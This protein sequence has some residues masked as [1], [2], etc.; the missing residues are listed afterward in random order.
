MSTENE[1]RLQA[2]NKCWICNKLFDAQDDKVREHC[3]TAGKYRGSAHWSCN[4]N[5]KLTKK[6]PAIFHNLKGYDS[7]LIMQ[8]IGKFDAKVSVIPSGLVKC[9]A[10]TIKK[11]LVF[12]DSMQFM[13]SG[14][15]ALTK[16]LSHNDSKYLSEKFSGDLLNLIKQKEVYPYEY[17]DS[18]KRFSE[19]QLSDR[20]KFFIFQ[21]CLK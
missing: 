4:I 18:F 11:N 16:N 6:V 21:M 2:S 5:L 17:M 3:H 14:L 1:E 13:N 7:H 19:D 8:E 10:F 9:I 20:C 15:D 12:I